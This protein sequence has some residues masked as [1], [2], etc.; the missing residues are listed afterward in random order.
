MNVRHIVIP[1]VAKK[2]IENAVYWTIKKETPFDDK[3]TVFDFE[4]QREVTEQGIGK[5]LKW[6]IRRPG[7][8]LTN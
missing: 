8:K 4:I 6:F 3:D 2:Q 1:K 7:R 5:W